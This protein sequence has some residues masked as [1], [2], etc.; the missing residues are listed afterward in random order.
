MESIG[1][2]LSSVRESLGFSIEQVARETNIAKSYLTALEQETFD[3]FPGEAYVIGF[4]RNYA[5]Y[6]G[7]DPE[8]MVTLY[9]NIKLQEQPS[10]IEE[11]LDIK[12]PMPKHILIIIIAA[13]VLAVVAGG[14]FYV[15]P[16]FIKGN[17]ADKPKV[18][19]EKDSPKKEEKP[20]IAAQKKTYEFTQD[21]LDQQL[22]KNDEVSISINGQVYILSL[23]DISD[24]VVISSPVGE[25]LLET[26]SEIPLDLD[27]DSSADLRLSLKSVDREASSIVLH[28]E[29]TEEKKTDG[30]SESAVL[31]ASETES[32]GSAGAPSRTVKTFV[33]RS[34]SRPSAFAVTA[35]FRGYCLFRYETNDGERVERYFH[36]GETFR[37]D[38][39]KSV[40]L[41]ASNAGAVSAKVNGVDIN[42]GGS[43]EV[44]SRLIK[45]NY[46]KDAG[47]YELQLLPLY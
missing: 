14:Y 27:G 21:S 45:W 33:I 3:V 42:I 18:H 8:Q 44:S 40:S 25:L 13:V 28:M 16:N 17:V 6:L 19:K 10:P 11:L 29:K 32:V 30:I 31:S 24:K 43:G 5:E 2:K 20:V 7:L 4:L 15:Y 37:L 38:A 12:K 41:W 39:N 47:K 46:N 36:K 26:H 1:Q 9:R 23:K 22:N 35:V 34:G